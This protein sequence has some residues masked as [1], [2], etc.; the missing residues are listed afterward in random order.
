[1]KSILYLSTILSFFSVIN[2][3][4]NNEKIFDVSEVNS[5]I[6]LSATD[7]TSEETKLLDQSGYKF[8]SKGGK[9]FSWMLHP[10]KNIICDGYVKRLKIENSGKLK[11]ICLACYS[12]KNELQ[13]MGA[14]ISIIRQP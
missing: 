2:A 13:H 8:V 5:N 7:L 14:T 3:Q 12:S 10:E 4:V 1:M 11:S 6:T 9:Q